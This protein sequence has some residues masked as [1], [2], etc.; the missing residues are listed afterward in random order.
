MLIE[1]NALV[2]ATSHAFERSW[3]S[4]FCKDNGTG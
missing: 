1:G 3:G 4:I 2:G